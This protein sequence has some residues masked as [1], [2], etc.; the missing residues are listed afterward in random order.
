M[1]KKARSKQLTCMVL[2]DQPELLR[3]LG[4]A[5]LQGDGTFLVKVYRNLE[6]N[7]AKRMLQQLAANGQ[8]GTVSGDF[9]TICR[10]QT[11]QAPRPPKPRPAR[12][13][14]AAAIEKFA[15]DNQQARFVAG[16][17]LELYAKDGVGAEIIRQLI[18]FGLT[19]EAF[20]DFWKRH[21]RKQGG[22]PA[23]HDAWSAG[24]LDDMA[25]DAK[26]ASTDAVPATRSLKQLFDAVADDIE[27]AKTPLRIIV[28]IRLKGSPEAARQILAT[29][30][31]NEVT[32]RDFVHFWTDLYEPLDDPYGEFLADWFRNNL[33][34]SL[35]VF[36]GEAIAA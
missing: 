17:L 1:A 10:A 30:I 14:H 24:T 21:F 6:Y 35:T 28:H 18:K 12:S 7:T 22:I 11:E 34:D 23:L 36:A 5:D 13:R 4:V 15:G 9:G 3:P 19:G 27:L 25:Q 33:L 2:T 29:L 32:G 26:P 16:K 8:A 31:N 20:Q